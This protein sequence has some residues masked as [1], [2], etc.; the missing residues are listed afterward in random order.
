MRY[1]D[2]YC[3]STAPTE[4]TTL[5]REVE[6]RD[7]LIAELRR[8]L[9][10]ARALTSDLLALSDRLGGYRRTEDTMLVRRAKSWRGEWR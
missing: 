9:E 7:A 2:G 3:T 8:D 5:G 4:S 1:E 6:Q 10:I